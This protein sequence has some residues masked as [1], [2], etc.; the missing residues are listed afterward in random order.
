MIE[1]YL[2]HEEERNALGIPAL[3]LNPEQTAQLCELLQNPPAGKEEFLLNL[4]TERVSPGVDPAA[5]VK[6]G[7]LAEILQGVK[8]SPL[9]SKSQAIKILGTMIG[10][11][12]VQPLIGALSDAELAD[13]AACALSG[14]T[15]VY[16]AAAQV[17][18]LAKSH[19]AAKKVAESW[20]AAEWFTSKPEMPETITVK[21][22]KVEGEINTDDFSPAGDAW[23]RPDIPLHALAMG[24]TRFP[25]GIEEIATWRAEG[26]QVAFV[27]D[28]V[29]TGSSRKSA[30]NSVLWHI[31]EDIP[32][33]PNKRRGGVI[34]GGVIAPIFF[35]TAQDSGALP[36]RMDVTKMNMGDIITINTAK[37]EVTNEA[38]KVVSTFEIKPNTVPDE[39]RAGGRIPLIIGRS[40]TTQAREALGMDEINI[41]AQPDN[42]TPK[43]GQGYSLAQKMVGRACGVEGILPGTAC[44][45]KMTTVGSQDTTGPMT[46]DELK[47][48]ACL[49]FQSPMFMQSFCHTA[50]YPKPADVKMHKNLPGFIAERE[51]VA[52]RPGDGVI[53]SWLN[54]L[55]VPDTVGTGGDSHTRFPVGISFPAGSGLVA[56]AGALGFMPL[57]MPESVLVR[58]KGEFNP[59]ITLRDAVNAIPLWAIKQGLMTVP[60]K[61][62]INVFNGRILEMEGLPN[63]SVEQAF[64]LTDAA[65]ERS[66]AAGCI[67]LSEESVCTYLR[68]NIAL[69]EKMIEEGYQHAG[70]LRRRIED[71]K[72]WLKDPKLLRADSN[73]EYAAVIEIDLAEITEPILACPNDPDDVKV[74]SEVAGTEINDVFL[75]SC[76][77]NIGH[78]RAAAEIWRGQKFN[79]S[80]RT[81]VCPPTRMD[82][83]KL[84]EEAVFS[85]FSAMGAR[86]EIAGCSLCM[87]NQ[88]RVPDGVTMFSTSTRNFDD[89]IGNGAKVY[90]GSAELGAVTST[91]GKLPTPD[92]Y[93]AVYNEKVAPKKDEIYKYLQFDEM[94]G[95]GKNA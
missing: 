67:Q 82:Q 14:L 5:E 79:P 81:W 73:A 17:L 88:A 40:V 20:A 90:L 1:S 85:V 69:M 65:A 83:A 41:F 7:F 13:E 12:N 63:L 77:T 95:Y 2:R 8:S 50:A 59:G 54:R 51:G 47:E 53:H 70:T 38:G 92:E 42:P 32:A 16:D 84:K 46:A 34:I 27:G 66:A 24:K 36:L 91:L 39:F 68:S 62:K 3:P 64:E 23:S 33:V 22:F 74:L 30:C 86:I 49:K 26:H 31:G 89:R 72:E 37:G 6:A 10:G 55:L 87:G 28:V 35:N 52:L 25:G 11:Y 45:P 9:I 43:A 71:V 80:V 76:M 78:F 15:Y 93:L 44:E 75:G 19:D 4:F 58:F 60:K 29:G 56:F 57:D 61:N 94:D 48:L 18:E 21:V